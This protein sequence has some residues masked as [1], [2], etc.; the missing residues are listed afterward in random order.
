MGTK[1][2]YIVSLGKSLKSL[3][4]IVAIK[5]C[6]V[7]P[8]VLFTANFEVSPVPKFPSVTSPHMGFHL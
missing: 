6:S 5:F 8:R 4:M 3:Q 7:S 2:Q 1:D